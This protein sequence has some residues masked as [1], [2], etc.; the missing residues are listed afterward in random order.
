MRR[1]REIGKLS[2]PL[3][4]HVLPVFFRGR[5]HSRR[6]YE[7]PQ[8]GG[9]DLRDDVRA[10]LLVSRRDLR[11]P[12]DSLPRFSLAGTISRGR[13]RR[14][15]VKLERSPSGRGLPGYASDGV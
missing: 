11:L 5:S 4:A 13:S 12:M 9:V 15:R 14:L 10:T 1:T 2:K 8:R 3:E 7:V 6:P